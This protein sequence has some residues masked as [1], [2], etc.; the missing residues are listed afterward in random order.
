MVLQY[1]LSWSQV[2][3]LSMRACPSFSD[4]ECLLRLALG[5]NLK[6]TDSGYSTLE[7]CNVEKRGRRAHWPF[8]DSMLA[9]KMKQCLALPQQF[10]LIES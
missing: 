7:V 6:R 3:V 5:S 8:L 1:F 9:K 2:L 10:P 4:H